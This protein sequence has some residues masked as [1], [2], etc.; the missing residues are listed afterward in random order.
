MKRTTKAAIS[1]YTKQICIDC[2]NLAE[3]DGMGARSIGEKLCKEKS[4]INWDKV[5]A[6]L[7]VESVD[8]GKEWIETK[9]EKLILPFVTF[10]DEIVSQIEALQLDAAKEFDFRMTEMNVSGMRIIK[11][12]KNTLVVEK[13]ENYP[14]R[15]LIEL[16]HVG[17][18]SFN[19][20][21]TRPKDKQNINTE[22]DEE[23]ALELLQYYHPL[24]LNKSMVK[25]Y[26][27]KPKFTIE[28]KKLTN[29]RAKACASI[30]FLE[31]EWIRRRDVT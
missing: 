12:N 28:G 22:S 8:K 26:K 30:F 16:T 15:T 17:N 29:I 18:L 27:V 4:I 11:N 2:Y 19:L 6:I 7:K 25:F 23:L 21:V 10:H 20:C 1:K 13:D 31:E 24:G 9:L 14:A 5:I 3:Q